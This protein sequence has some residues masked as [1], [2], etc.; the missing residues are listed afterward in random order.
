[1]EETLPYGMLQENREAI[2]VDVQERFQDDVSDLPDE[3]REESENKITEQER[4]EIA[5]LDHVEGSLGD[6]KSSE[7]GRILELLSQ[8][9]N[10]SRRNNYECG[11]SGKKR[12][13]PY[14]VRAGC[15]SKSTG[16]TS[17]EA[18]PVPVP[19]INILATSSSCGAK[20]FA[21]L[22]QNFWILT[23]AIAGFMIRYL[24]NKKY[25]IFSLY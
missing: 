21:F 24:R 17:K 12:N 25:I 9:Q 7:F 15:C 8:S 14:W 18:L 11:G 4:R 23:I 10:I 13:Y 1:M 3:L 2:V 5:G 16:K 19:I 22:A 20:G 6:S